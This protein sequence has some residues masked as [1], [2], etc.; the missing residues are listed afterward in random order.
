MPIRHKARPFT[1]GVRSAGS[2]GPEGPG[3]A[4]V[5]YLF[6]FLCVLAAPDT[7]ADSRSDFLKLIDRP[8]VDLAPKVESLPPHENLAEFHFTYAS[9]SE[10]RVPGILVKPAQATGR[11]P[12]VIVLHG[13]GG[14]KEGQL[15]LLRDL[16]GLGFVAVAIDGRY[17]GERTKAGKGSEE[18]QQAILK[19]FREQREHPFFFD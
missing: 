2:P 8:R 18:Y 17:H 15:S 11:S 5:V 12:V 9:D 19:A 4:S 7:R 13:T 14:N 10:N 1:A 16:A 3:F 6:I